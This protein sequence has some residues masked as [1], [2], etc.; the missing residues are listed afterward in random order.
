MNKIRS[1]RHSIFDPEVSCPFKDPNVNRAILVQVL[2]ENDWLEKGAGKS[3]LVGGLHQ[4]K[5]KEQNN[6]HSD[7][8]ITAIL[9]S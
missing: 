1:L 2:P 3:V 8:P 5:A 6:V 7:T 4:K 9:V